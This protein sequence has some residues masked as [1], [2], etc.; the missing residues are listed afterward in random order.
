MMKN[1]RPVTLSVR[2]GPRSLVFPWSS[3]ALSQKSDGE[4]DDWLMRQN[5][6]AGELGTLAELFGRL[7][8]PNELT[9]LG[10]PNL[11]RVSKV[12]QRRL[13]P[14]VARQ[15]RQIQASRK[16]LIAERKALAK[17]RSAAQASQS[18][19]VTAP[20]HVSPSP[21]SLP[22]ASPTPV[23]TAAPAA[24]PPKSLEPVVEPLI[25]PVE[26][27]ATI[28]PAQSP[29]TQTAFVPDYLPPPAVPQVVV[30]VPQMVQ[31]SPAA[32]APEPPGQAAFAPPGASAHAVPSPATPPVPIV[33]VPAVYSTPAYRP[34]VYP[35]PLTE[36][37]GA[38]D[39]ED[40]SGDY[41]EFG[42]TEPQKTVFGELL[43]GAGLLGM[44]AWLIAR[45]T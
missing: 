7:S 2:I 4:I 37:D 6:S 14:P 38:W 41:E 40:Y 45:K 42:N 19:A 11:G 39:E 8:C 24:E 18:A 1:S 25:P 28:A 26:R 17:A 33:P 10:D 34:P 16:K 27:Q 32:T 12:A 20:P 21:V 35:Y 30:Q 44:L 36:D 29:V 43:A 15:L 23:A 13:P 9:P 31:A 5:L 3:G 22:P